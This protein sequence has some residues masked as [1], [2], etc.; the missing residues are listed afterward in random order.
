M[1]GAFS[2]ASPVPLSQIRSDGEDSLAVQLELLP[3]RVDEEG[4]NPKTRPWGKIITV[5]AAKTRNMIL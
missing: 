3:S 1:G 2:A 4:I 5:A